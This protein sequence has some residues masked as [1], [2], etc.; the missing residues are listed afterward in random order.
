[1]KRIYDVILVSAKLN[2]ITFVIKVMVSLVS[3][4]SDLEMVF[5]LCW[6][7]L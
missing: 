2:S 1:M 5:S 7:F 6:S 4:K 3:L